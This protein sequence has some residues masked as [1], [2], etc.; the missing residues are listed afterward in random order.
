LEEVDF[1]FG[2]TIQIPILQMV[3]Q[4]SEVLKILIDLPELIFG[5]IFE[6]EVRFI[7]E[8]LLYDLLAVQLQSEVLLEDLRN[9]IIDHSNAIED[10]FQQA[11]CNSLHENLTAFL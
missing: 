4:F 2:K 8:V 10:D 7:A 6:E 3:G 5:D 1:K 9:L 11:I